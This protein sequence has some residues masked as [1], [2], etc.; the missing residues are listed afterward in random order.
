MSETA[1]TKT[2]VLCPACENDR[3]DV[4]STR[5]VSGRI[6]RVRRCCRCQHRFKTGEHVTCA[7]SEAVP[8]RGHRRNS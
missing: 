1:T 5:R 2:G 4:L 8:Q 7:I 3:S 6:V